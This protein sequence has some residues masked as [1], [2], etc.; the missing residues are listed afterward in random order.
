MKAKTKKDMSAVTSS[1]TNPHLTVKEELEVL[2]KMID[3]GLLHELNRRFLNPLG[4]S[5]GVSVDDDGKVDK[6]HFSLYISDDGV[7]LFLKLN[8]EKMKAFKK[9]ADSASIVN[10]YIGINRP[11]SRD[12]SIKNDNKIVK[13]LSKMLKDDDLSKVLVSHL[14]MLVPEKSEDKTAPKKR[15]K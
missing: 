2:Q 8:R 12:I 15:G 1:D 7:W 5:M 4:L 3:N 6:N 9:W 14:S 10:N 11:Q 13:G